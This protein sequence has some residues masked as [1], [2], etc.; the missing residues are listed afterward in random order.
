[1]LGPFELQKGFLSREPEFPQ[2]DVRERA[3]ARAVGLQHAEVLEL[4]QLACFAGE[5]DFH[6]VGGLHLRH[7]QS[8]LGDMV[9]ELSD[10]L[11][12]A[13]RCARVFHDGF[14]LPDVLGAGRAQALDHLAKG[15]EHL[16]QLVALTQP[17][18]DDKA[19]APNITG[20]TSPVSIAAL[21][22]LIV[23]S[24]V[25]SKVSRYFSRSSSSV[26]ATVS[27]R[28][29]QAASTWS[30]NSL[31]TSPSVTVPEPSAFQVNALRLNRSI[32]PLNPLSL[33][34]GT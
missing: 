4:R 17:T 20:T 32:T 19:A 21:N 33:P 5:S 10:D 24:S 26:D 6:I 34:I 14:E 22:A 13:P 18:F 7:G 15:F 11:T 23:S 3:G 31:G 8:G 16:L 27:T 30:E 28:F 2:F 25:N 29:S 9:P 12:V 1:M